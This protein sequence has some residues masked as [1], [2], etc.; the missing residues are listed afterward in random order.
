MTEE[1]SGLRI[2]HNVGHTD[3]SGDEFFRI[4]AST[5]AI[6]TNAYYQ[7]EFTVSGTFETNDDLQIVRCYLPFQ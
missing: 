6:R 3:G 7:M 5:V 2:P 4:N 1:T